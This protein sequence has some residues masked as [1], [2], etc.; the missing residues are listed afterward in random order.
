VGCCARMPK[1]AR[2]PHAGALRG[3]RHRRLGGCAAP[4]G[5][6]GRRPARRP[7]VA[8][9]QGVHLVVD[10]D[11]SAR[12]PRAAGAQDRRWPGAVCRAV[13]GQADPGHHR[14]AAH[15]TCRWS[16]AAGA[17]GGLHPARGGQ[18]PQARA[19]RSAADVRSTWAGLRPLVKPAGS[20][21]GNTKAISREHT[22]LVAGPAWSPSPA[23]NGPPTAPWP[24]TCWR[25]AVL[26]RRS[27]LLFTDAR[28]A[29]SLA[30]QVGAILR[31]ETRQDPQIA[32]L[33]G[34]PASIRPCPSDWLAAGV[35]TR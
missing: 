4:A 33:A 29:G 24:P 26:A 27:R 13:A 25:A 19:D 28:M 1:R 16:R 7:M 32:A 23:A 2:I 17:R 18:V 15:A 3:Q 35:L 8:P 5:R 6:R 9:S 20:E 31:D 22:V 10:Q 12:R 11:V 30:D 14:H 34:W 21:G